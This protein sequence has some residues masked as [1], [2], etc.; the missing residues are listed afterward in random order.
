M[1]ILSSLG[2]GNF[3]AISKDECPC[4]NDANS[5]CDLKECS[6]SMHANDLCEA[7]QQLPDGNP[8]FDIKNCAMLQ[9]VFRYVEGIPMSI[10][11]H[12]TVSAGIMYFNKL[13][14]RIPIFIF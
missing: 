11:K 10:N 9:D 7:N 5:G 3:I 12:W 14:Q 13:N 4:E 6:Y 2:T 1:Q 8:N